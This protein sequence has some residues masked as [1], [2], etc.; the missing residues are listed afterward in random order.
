M[1]SVVWML[2]FLASVCLAVWDDEAFKVDWHLPQI[3]HV[4]TVLT[5]RLAN[6]RIHVVTDDNVLAGLYMGQVQWRILLGGKAEAIDFKE[7][8]ATAVNNA[9]GSSTVSIW[10]QESG[11]LVKEVGTFTQ[12]TVAL[13]ARSED[14][15]VILEDGSVFLLNSQGD[16]TSV[17]SVKGEVDQLHVF[18]NGNIVVHIHDALGN[19]SYAFYNGSEIVQSPISLKTRDVRGIYGSKIIVGSN[20]KHHCYRINQKTGEHYSGVELPQVDSLINIDSTSLLAFQ[21]GNDLKVHSIEAEEQFVIPNVYRYDFQFV[22]GVFVMH[23]EYHANVIDADTGDEI[24]SHQ[25]GDHKLEFDEIEAIHTKT[26]GVDRIYTLIQYKSG[27]LEFLRN[28]KSFWRRDFSLS[29]SVAHAILDIEVEGSLT[30]DE[31]IQEEV[32]PIWEAYFS[33]IIRHY[34]ELRA[35]YE[36]FWQ[37]LPLWTTGEWT[38][39][40]INNDK[41]FGFEKIL[42]LANNRGYVTALNSV[43]GEKVWVFSTEQRDIYQM[44][45]FDDGQLYIFTKSGPLFIL[46]SKTGELISQE[47]LAPSSSIKRLHDKSLLV[48]TSEGLNV[49]AGHNNGTS[50]TTSHDAHTIKGFKIVEDS[51]KPSWT[52][53]TK[54]HEIIVG[55]SEKNTEELVAN[56]GIVLGDRSVLYKYLYPNLAAVAV[57]NNNTKALYLNIIDTLTGELLHSVVHDTDVLGDSVSVVFGEHWVVYTFYSNK[58]TPEQ[59][60][61]VI[62]LFE[63]LVP[64]TR[65]SKDSESS[66]GARHPPAISTKSFILPVKVSTLAI[67]KTRFG[68]TTKAVVFSLENGQLLLVPKFILNSRRVFGRELTN[69]EKAQF[70]LLPYDPVIS[71]DDHSVI[72]HKR[73]VLGQETIVSMATNLE[74]T[75]IVCSYGLD[76]FCTRVSPSSQFDKLTSSFDKIKLVGSIIILVFLVFFLRPMRESKILK[77]LWVVEAPN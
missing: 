7:Q 1:V 18:D 42:I 62:D 68:V 51:I 43:N 77:N 74:S 26:D 37:I 22:D 56:I 63:S 57:W 61:V 41:Y 47:L 35:L 70:R 9:D 64:N 48:E 24:V 32:L 2:T 55:Y 75:S 69:E 44:E 38:F 21:H 33:R 53:I 58:P 73:Q 25:L 4:N 76:V 45:I 39:P 13:A 27:E 54:P 11:F 8:I 3:G 60:V 28:A 52:F 10:D 15:V 36:R 72:S 23:T 16:T 20:G 14:L 34:Q 49:V 30:G 71:I 67:T 46:D 17:G 66:F 5:S 19:S 59:H 12:P 50:Y 31:L 65:L 29:D 40:T 6:D